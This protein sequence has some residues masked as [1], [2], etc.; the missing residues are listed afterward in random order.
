M[1]VSINFRWDNKPRWWYRVFACKH[2]VGIWDEIASRYATHT[3]YMLCRKCGRSAMDIERYC[4]HDVDCFGVCRYCK[5]R[6]TK[7]D[8]KHKEWCQEPD[9]DDYYC[10][11]C[12]VWKDEAE[13]KYYD[14]L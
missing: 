9:T 3:S 12:G 8:C 7:K 5:Q 2:E 13:G 1:N 6:Q 4:K 14:E 11:N 10:N